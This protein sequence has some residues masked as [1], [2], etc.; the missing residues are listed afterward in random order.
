[1]GDGG[2]IYGFW[3]YSEIN[4]ILTILYP[5]DRLKNLLETLDIKTNRRLSP[6]EIVSWVRRRPLSS[7]LHGHFEPVAD[8][9]LDPPLPWSESRLPSVAEPFFPG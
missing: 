5:W 1:M 2:G 9:A 8:F 6:R 3:L 4:I 7:R